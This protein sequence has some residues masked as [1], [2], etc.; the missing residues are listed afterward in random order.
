MLQNITRHIPL[1]TIIVSYFFICGGLYLIGFWTTFNVDIANLVSITDIPKSFIFPFVISQG[2][3]GFNMLINI[4]TANSFRDANEELQPPNSRKKPFW[5]KALYILI[6][7]DFIILYSSLFIINYYF[8]YKLT[9]EY[10]LISSGVLIFLLSFKFDNFSSLKKL[11]PYYNL[12]MYIVNTAISVPLLSFAIG[13]SNSLK[14]YNN[15][16][17]RYVKIISEPTHKGNTDSSP[18]KFIGFLGDK[19]I[20]SSL[21]NK[22]LVFINQSS[23]DQVQ[24]NESK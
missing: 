12:R 1:T 21:D 8:R 14:T 19:L 20:A 24:L 22:K 4:V 3:Y 2:F 13:K 5:K 11:I 17:I 16:E 7:L 6:S 9:P 18:L 23:F 10:W 15:K